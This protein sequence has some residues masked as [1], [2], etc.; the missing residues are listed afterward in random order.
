MDCESY[1]YYSICLCTPGTHIV[2]LSLGYIGEKRNEKRSNS[3]RRICILGDAVVVQATHGLE[4]G[5]V[6]YHVAR[7]TYAQQAPFE[8]E[9]LEIRTE[10]AW[11]ELRHAVFLRICRLVA[12]SFP[13]AVKCS[14]RQFGSFVRDP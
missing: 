13:E 10:H 1:Y 4:R 9:L 6:S 2:T 12:T 11:A 3:W 14:S 7:V 8:S 5:E